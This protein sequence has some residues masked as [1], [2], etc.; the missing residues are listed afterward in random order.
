MCT[1]SFKV[2]V[3]FVSFLESVKVKKIPRSVK[4]EKIENRTFTKYWDLKRMPSSEIKRNMKLNLLIVAHHMALLRFE[5]LISSKAGT[6]SKM[7]KCQK[8][9]RM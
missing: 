8:H 4:R 1:P 5:L 6:V 3:L 7:N 9:R 2:L